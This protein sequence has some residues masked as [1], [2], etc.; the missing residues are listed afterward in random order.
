M[1]KKNR[2]KSNK[3]LPK[4]EIFVCALA[5]GCDRA[6]AYAKAYPK[7]A[8]KPETTRSQSA[9]NLLQRP[10]VMAAYQLELEK[11][12]A[13]EAERNR[14]TYERSVEVRLNAIK[15]IEEER[16]RRRI[17]QDALAQVIM[18]HPPEGMSQ[19]EAVIEAQKILMMPI[20]TTQTTTAVAQLCDGL[21]KLT[22]LQ[23]EDGSNQMN[24]IF[25]NDFRDVE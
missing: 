12:R 22:G 2:K 21:D 17:A 7:S 6:E 11:H 9:Y 14:W 20:L 1:R 13:E 4:H 19:E 24:V 10:E 3:L 16:E 8:N 15:A 23:K 25:S 5:S 18:E